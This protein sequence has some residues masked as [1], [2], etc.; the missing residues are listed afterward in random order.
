VSWPDGASG[1]WTCTLANETFGVP[2]AFTISYFRGGWNLT[3]TQAAVT[4][5][6]EGTIT[7]RPALTIA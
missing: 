3:V 1:V 4:R 2:D 7:G 6:D 5:D